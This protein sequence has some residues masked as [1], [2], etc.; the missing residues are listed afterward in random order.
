M[1]LGFLKKKTKCMHFC[2]KRKLH[3]NPCLK[4]ERTEI[5]VVNEHKFLGL[6]FNKK[7]AFYSPPEVL[8]V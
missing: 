4:L 7:T 3:N 8:K 2:H 1:A 5:P 6:V